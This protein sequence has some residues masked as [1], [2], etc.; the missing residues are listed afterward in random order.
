MG[1][2]G[3]ASPT[4]VRQ[5]AAPVQD[6]PVFQS[7]S[8][9]SVTT[10]LRDHWRFSAA[11]AGT[12][13]SSSG[14]AWLPRPSS[15]SSVL[16]PEERPCAGSAPA[17]TSAGASKCERATTFAKP[18]LRRQY[19]SSAKDHRGTDADLP[20]RPNMAGDGW[21][22]PLSVASSPTR[23][24]TAT[25]AIVTTGQQANPR[26]NGDCWQRATFRAIPSIRPRGGCLQSIFSDHMTLFV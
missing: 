11:P 4:P 25:T 23:A 7:A 5:A 1:R 26:F 12:C 17:S 3:P 8:A 6:R 13:R 10:T 20:V 24:I 22:H 14:R 21:L 18:P 15:R 19:C 2:A 16:A 9:A